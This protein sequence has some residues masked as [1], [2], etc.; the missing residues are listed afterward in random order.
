MQLQKVPQEMK[1]LALNLPAITDKCGSHLTYQAFTECGTTWLGSH[2]D[3]VPK[4]PQTYTAI[5]DLCVNVLDPV[6]NHFGAIK[7][8]YAFASAAL[9]KLVQKKANPNITPRGDQHARIA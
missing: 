9:S 8:T 5:R 7:L 1:V 3:N 4:R 6:I 2:V